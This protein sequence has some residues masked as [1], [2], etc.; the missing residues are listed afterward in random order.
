[1][2]HPKPPAK[3]SCQ[4]AL[5]VN[6]QLELGK[7]GTPT[8]PVLS[9]ALNSTKNFW[10]RRLLHCEEHPKKKLRQWEKNMEEWWWFHKFQKFLF[11]NKNT[12]LPSFWC[13]Q[14]GP[15]PYELPSEHSGAYSH[16][17]FYHLV[18]TRRFISL[19]ERHFQVG[20]LR[21]EACDW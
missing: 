13:L 14:N 8:Y 12:T 15:T 16:Q 1:M 17:A 6:S 18:R 21:I 4:G 11:F 2:T 20:C 9:V 19:W 5:V 7:A 10:S 3:R